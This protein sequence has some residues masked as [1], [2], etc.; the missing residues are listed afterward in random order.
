MEMY[1]PFARLPSQNSFGKDMS[2]HIV[3]ENLPDYTGKWDQMR[4]LLGSIRK[5]RKKMCEEEGGGE[6]GETGGDN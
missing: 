6:E 2:E 5:K 4:G 3:F 1:S